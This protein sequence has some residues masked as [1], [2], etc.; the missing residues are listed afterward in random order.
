[1]SDKPFQIKS[2]PEL[3]FQS[4]QNIDFTL[5]DFVEFTDDNVRLEYHTEDF[6]EGFQVDGETGRVT[7]T[8]PIVPIDTPYLVCVTFKAKQTEQSVTQYFAIQIN[9]T[10]AH[11]ASENF[12]QSILDAIKASQDYDQPYHPYLIKYLEYILENRFPVVYIYNSAQPPQGFGKLIKTRTSEAGFS[13]YRFDNLVAITSGQRAYAEGNRGAILKTLRE[14]YT[15]DLAAYN[16][17]YIGLSCSDSRTLG[18]AWVLA[19]LAGLNVIET[20]PTERAAA[21]YRNLMK[22][23]GDTPRPI[24]RLTI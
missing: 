13:I 4:G 16:W 8:A 9:G 11:F 12:Q 3:I 18:K 20:A 2:I 5:E 1:M 22:E 24:M 15:Q 6:P 7:G 19:K 10:H 23:L 21:V 14:V 17:N